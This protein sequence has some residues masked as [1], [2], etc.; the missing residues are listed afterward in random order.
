MRLRIEFLYSGHK[1]DGKIK[2]IGYKK[3]VLGWS[4]HKVTGSPYHDVDYRNEIFYN[5]KGLYGLPLS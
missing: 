4:I 5:G 2:I 1:R 3:R